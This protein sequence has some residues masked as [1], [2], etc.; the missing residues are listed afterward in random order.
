MPPP[1]PIMEDKKDV[2]KAATIKTGE[3]TQAQEEYTTSGF[4][5]DAQDKW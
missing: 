3:I 4:G 2:K 5:T 1:R